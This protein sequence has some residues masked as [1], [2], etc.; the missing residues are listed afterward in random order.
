MAKGSLK[1]R[2]IWLPSFYGRLTLLLFLL[3]LLILYFYIVG[4]SQGFVDKTLSFLFILESWILSFC[5]LAG[6]FS[7]ISYAVTLPLRN[8]LQL[9]RIILSAAASLFSVILYLLVAII[10]AFMDSYG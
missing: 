7:T 3:S 5:A 6:I 10:Q 4:N 1:L 8:R 2:R 9:D